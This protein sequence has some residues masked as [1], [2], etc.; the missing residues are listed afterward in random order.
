MTQGKLAMDLGDLAAAE[1]VFAGLAADP[2]ASAHMRAEAQVRLGV[3]QRALGKASASAASF[4]G[5]I[6]SPA[7]D[8]EVTRLLALALAGVAPDRRSW[9]T[10]WP[11][12]RFTA[13]TGPAGRSPSI[14]W[15]GVPP[16]DVQALFPGSGPVTIDLEDVPLSA[17][18]H[19]FLLAWRP[20]LQ[21]AR[22]WPGPRAEAGYGFETWP[23]PF[24]PPA[25]I[26]RLDFV[27]HSG[28]ERPLA[29]GSTD[30]LGPRVTVKAAGMPWSELFENVLASNGL[31]LVIDGGILFIARTEDLATFDRVRQRRYADLPISLNFLD[32]DLRDV[33]RLLAEVSGLQL[34]PDGDLP[35]AFTTVV[36]E[37]PVMEVLD[38]LLAANDLAATRVPVPDGDQAATALR[39]RKLAAAGGDAVDVSQLRPVGHAPSRL[40]GFTARAGSTSPASEPGGRFTSIEGVVQVRKAGTLAWTP[41][42]RDTQLRPG[43][44]V[45]TGPGAAEILWADGTA[46]QLKE[47]GLVAVEE[48]P[49]AGKVKVISAPGPEP[50]ND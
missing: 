42:S 3:V 4:Q 41:A 28:V 31:G 33:F 20:G 7:R 13:P 27:I 34:V 5:A 1:R 39:I 19:H 26:R 11:R 30:A 32:G 44:L 8:A 14:R 24:E 49:E 50:R 48:R 21:S 47:H 40:P 6:E 38:L 17:F 18:L 23:T 25:A 16:P 15:P 10:E 29:G 22:S 2:V 12:V 37:R 46:F 36:T 9:A 45:R 35:G 43:D